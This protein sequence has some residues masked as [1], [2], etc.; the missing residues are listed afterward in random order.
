MFELKNENY[1]F[2]DIKQPI[3]QYFALPNDVIFF[4]N[5]KDEVL[6]SNLKVLPTLFPLLNSKIKG[7]NPVLQIALK[8]NM[9][10]LDYILGD[11]QAKQALQME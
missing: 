7:E 8:C 11:E 10:T 5:D 1:T 4:K 3:A 9:S 2:G 6:L